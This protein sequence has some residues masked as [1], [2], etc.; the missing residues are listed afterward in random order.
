MELS[1]RAVNIVI[2]GA[3]G[4]LA[5][6]K[7]LPALFTLFCNG[8]LPERFQVVGFARTEMDDGSFRDL[9][10]STLTSR[11][12][13][14]PS[15]CDIK[16]GAFL[17]R[18]HY[19]AGAYDDA[20][21]FRALGR[22]LESLS[23]PQAPMLM[24]LSIPPSVFL[25]TAESIREAGLSD[26]TNRP[27]A[28]VVIE[29][30]FGRDS[31]SS[32]ELSDAISGIFREE[33]TFRIDHY[34]GKEVIQNLLILRFGNRMFE[35]LWHRDHIESVSVEFAET[36]GLEGRAG[37]FDSFGIIRDVLQNHLLQAVALVAMEQPISL[38]SQEIA[39]EKSKVLRAARPLSRDE[40]AVGRYAGYATEK[41]VASDSITETS[42]AT[43][44]HI[45]T[46]RWYGVPFYLSAG[47]A[48]GVRRTEI[49]VRFRP[50]PWS[51]F[52]GLETN[53]LRIRVQ[54]EEAIEL[55][56][57]NKVPGMK[58]EA[59]AV[60]LNMLYHEEFDGA[61]PEAYERLLLDTIRGDR[62]LFIQRHELDA[63][64]RIVTPLLHGL[65]EQRTAPEEYP[66]G[67]PAPRPAGWEDRHGS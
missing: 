13:P 54:P 65:E 67:G 48:L 6:K 34:L 16:V 61:L 20:D 28:R 14:E 35:P 29:K 10:A 7:L 53:A 18:C 5:R 26:E 66:V 62:A 45:D 58:L 52:D 27:W 39:L 43:V 59:A 41:G 15:Q 55:V 23:G 17:K 38:E 44:L 40:T 64:W 12:E 42:V 49:T 21:A 51:L 22:R 46:P 1:T 37:Y 30:P 63:A 8:L 2:V 56:V 19:H 11:Y 36:I 4:D 9:V 33:Q 50:L 32:A 25:A 47:K 57:N 31:A 24:Y 3:S 60:K